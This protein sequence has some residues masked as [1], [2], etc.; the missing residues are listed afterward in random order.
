MTFTVLPA[1]FT[2]LASAPAVKAPMTNAVAANVLAHFIS[3]SS[4]MRI[5]SARLT[6]AQFTRT[7]AFRS[8]IFRFGH[9]CVFGLIVILIHCAAAGRA[10]HRKEGRW[11]VHRATPMFHIA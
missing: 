11:P 4:L 7:S 1:K 8:R 3:L 6:A 9:F 10:L 2:L 5:V